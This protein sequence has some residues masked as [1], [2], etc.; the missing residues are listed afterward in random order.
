MDQK[1]KPA[2]RRYMYKKKNSVRP[3]RIERDAYNLY[4]RLYRQSTPHRL[5]NARKASSKWKHL[6]PDWRPRRPPFNVILSKGKIRKVFNMVMDAARFLD[7]SST[8]ISNAAY[9]RVNSVYGWQIEYK[10]VDT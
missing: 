6:N 4:H 10:L 8:S 9:G 5:N 2:L 1:Q 3:T 7:C